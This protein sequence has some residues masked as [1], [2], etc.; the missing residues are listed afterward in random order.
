[1]CW[2]AVHGRAE[3]IL[4]SVDAFASSNLVQ[5]PRFSVK[6]M[7][8]ETPSVCWATQMLCTVSLYWRVSKAS[9]GSTGQGNT[10]VYWCFSSNV[11]VD[12]CCCVYV[13]VIGWSV[14]GSLV[15]KRKSCQLALLSTSTLR[16]W[17][18]KGNPSIWWVGQ[19]KSSSQAQVLSACSVESKYSKK[20]SGSTESK[21]GDGAT[22]PKYV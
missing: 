10:Y 2:A 1:M 12:Y 20:F 18:G 9:S 13:L 14:K 22:K 8:L 15:R 17:V 21:Q 5:L 16:S 7:W 4:R 6:R 11:R 19:R 3:T